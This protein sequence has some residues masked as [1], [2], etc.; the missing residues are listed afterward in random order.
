MDNQI[1]TRYLVCAL[2]GSTCTEEITV[3][4]DKGIIQQTKL[5]KRIFHRPENLSLKPKHE[6]K[7][8]KNYSGL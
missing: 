5:G 7:T 8:I 3:I 1:E 2:Y 4:T 6:G